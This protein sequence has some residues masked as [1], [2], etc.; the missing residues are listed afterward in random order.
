MGSVAP[1]RGDRIV[2][3]LEALAVVA[4]SWLV[5]GYLAILAV[6]ATVAAVS[7]FLRGPGA[8]ATLPVFAF[9]AVVCTAAILGIV[10]LARLSG[11]VVKLLVG[12][13]IDRDLG[14]AKLRA[15]LRIALLP[16]VV[17]SLTAV[18]LAT[19]ATTPWFTRIAAVYVSGLPL[20]LPILHL[21][22]IFARDGHWDASDGPR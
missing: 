19:S 3:G 11:L 21:W 22:R 4:P 17:G 8:F 6:V 2:L 9:L 1:S 13:P 14:E 5:I 18:F 15:G 20:L 16:F 7:A 12:T 10:G